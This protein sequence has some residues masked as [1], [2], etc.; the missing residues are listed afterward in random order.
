MMDPFESIGTAPRPPRKDPFES[1]GTAPTPRK[2]QGLGHAHIEKNTAKI[3]D[4]EG[5]RC[6]FGTCVFC[7]PRFSQGRGGSESTPSPQD[8]LF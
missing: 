8:P 4:F 5:R 3:C 1:I 6:N 7:Y 2:T